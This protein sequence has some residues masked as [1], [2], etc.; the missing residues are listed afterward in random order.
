MTDGVSALGTALKALLPGHVLIVKNG[1][2]GLWGTY[3]W[4]R[5]TLT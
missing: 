1:L 2:L 5:R 3:N 4:A